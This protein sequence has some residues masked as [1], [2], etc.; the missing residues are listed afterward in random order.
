[1][2]HGEGSK[3][4]WDRI[5]MTSIKYMKQLLTLKTRC[6]GGSSTGASNKDQVAELSRLGRV[7]LPAGL[8]KLKQY[9]VQSGCKATPVADGL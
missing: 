6:F 3:R 7:Y 1:M 8:L 4:E 5:R 9:T 2:H